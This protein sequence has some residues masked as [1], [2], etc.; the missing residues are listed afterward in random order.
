MNQGDMTRLD[1]I[2]NDHI[3]YGFDVLFREFGKL[4]TREEIGRVIERRWGFGD[5]WYEWY[6]EDDD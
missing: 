3:G 6:G 1:F 5:L 2:M 4:Y